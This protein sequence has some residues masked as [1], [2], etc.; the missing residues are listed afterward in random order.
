MNTKTDADAYEQV[1]NEW[2]Y[3]LLSPAGNMDATDK[4]NGV[5]SKLA[6]EISNR[7]NAARQLIADR[8]KGL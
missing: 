3:Q 8:K 6:M 7:L 2:I 5:G 1:F 4:K